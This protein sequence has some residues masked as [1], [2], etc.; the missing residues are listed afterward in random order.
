MVAG[1]LVP[2]A[3]T[4]TAPLVASVALLARVLAGAASAEWTGWVGL[5]LVGAALVAFA[6]HGAP[7]ATG[8]AWRESVRAAPS[9]AAR[10]A[11]LEELRR[12]GRIHPDEYQR[13]RAR[14]LRP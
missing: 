12:E 8:Q 4:V 10:L 5:T 7:F 3:A 1:R 6:R 9:P 2:P 11:T 14:I 13:E